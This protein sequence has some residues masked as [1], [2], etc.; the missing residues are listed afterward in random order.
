MSNKFTE[1]AE[2]ALNGAVRV[3]EDFGHTYIGTEHILRSLLEDPVC[4]AA[5][6]LTKNGVT[7]EKVDSA[8]REYSGVGDKSTLSPRDMTPRCR[9]VVENSYKNSLKFGA[10][11][12]GTEH[13]LLSI[14]EEKESVA[15]KI[16][17]YIGVEASTLREE[18]L[19]F[20]RA[21]GKRAEA[22]R[23]AES[24]TPHLN[25]YG[26]N[27]TACAGAGK[28]DPV[29]G[30]EKETER[31]IRILC[32]KTKNNPCLIGEAGVGKTAI[33]EGLAE[34]IAAGDVPQVL[35][36]KQIFS[37]DLTSMVAGAKYRGDFEERVKA[38]LAE[39]AG[40]RDIILFI[41]EVHTIVGAGAAEGAI[42]AANILKPQ[43]SRGEI[44]LI[45]A[46]TLGEYHKYIE[47][48]PA[49][50][51]RF[52]PLMVEEP[53]DEQTLAILRGI[54]DRY[55]K[56]H[57]LLIDDGALV[58]CVTLSKRYIQGRFLPDKAIDLLDEACAKATVESSLK[59]ANIKNCKDKIEQIQKEKEEAVQNQDYSLALSLRDLE[60]LYRTE[61]QQEQKRCEEEAER[62]VTVDAS[63]IRQI[64]TEMTGIPTSGLTEAGE[65]QDLESALNA[66]VIGQ[67]EAVAIVASAI[68]RG[69]TGFRDPRRPLGVFLFIGES[70][71]GKTELAKALAEELFAT[72]N[73]LIRYDMSEFMEKHSVSK[74]IGSPP[75]YVG[76]EEGGT[77]TERI[78]RHPYS[79]VLF[80]EIEKAHPD[81]LNI[82]LQ[83]TD[84]G[85]LTDSSGRQVNFRQACILMTSNL[86]AE[87]MRSVGFTAAPKN[88]EQD[89]FE[90]LKKHF[91][92]EFLNRVDEIVLFR[93]LDRD[94]LHAIASKKLA[95]V[96]ARA[97]TQGFT[98]HF[99]ED[100]IRYFAEKSLHSGLGARPMARYI[101][102][103]VENEVAR[104]IV[105]ENIP[106]GAHITVSV[107][108]G[109]VSVGCERAGELSAPAAAPGD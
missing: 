5:A 77:L 59:N 103:E 79:V 47:K 20:L 88:A 58:A 95:E 8:I 44:Q 19:A 18:S 21:S 104:K 86:G 45:G 107:C 62:Q 82:L 6:I 9:K 30:R 89:V 22:P 85:R 81:V 3:A 96:A 98:L 61:L 78:R 39:A 57:K 24:T 12:I 87:K 1:K 64:I 27:L 66:R 93:P 50:E 55:E 60:T 36:N 4:C 105:R 56:H 101:T 17:H 92:T 100:L 63:H 37:V 34:K 91:R 13:I 43:L 2:K 102:K 48:D 28:L 53:S 109:K 108:D 23:S 29:I 10:S 80:D 94:A 42:D 51:R 49:L 99:S 38:L 26:K 65:M 16:I 75:G 70:G 11:R 32:R 84:D 106:E 35:R 33:V 15:V 54:K 41:D 83:I 97:A 40:N 69:K 76:Y 25:Q 67:T 68:L 14:L 90:T 73:S 46:T 74:L 7:R 31:V 71:V 52:Q 72:E